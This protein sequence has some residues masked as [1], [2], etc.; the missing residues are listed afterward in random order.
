MHR[1]YP[2]LF[3]PLDLGFTTL[4]NRMIMGSMH[5]GLEEAKGGMKRLARFYAERARGE[6][7]LIIT[8][9]IAPN[10]N[11]WTK[12][13]AARMSHRRHAKKHRI[14]TDSVHKAGGKICMQILHTG[15]YG[16]HPLCV[17]PSKLKSPISPFVPWRLTRRGIH[18]TI[19]DFVRA[20]ELAKLA[21]YDGVE[22]MGSEGYLINEFICQRTNQR[23]DEWGGSYEN[24]IRFPL[25]IV[26]QTRKRVGED[27]III[28][29][30]SMLDLVEGGSSWDEVIRLARAMEQA[31]ATIINTGIGWHES[32][33]PT[34]ATMVPRGA[35]RWVTQKLKPEI[36]IPLIASNRIN[37][38][39][40]ADQTISDGYA[41]L[42][43][44][45]RPFLADASFV[46]KA[47]K[48]EPQ[49]I[50]T[51]IACNQACLDHIFNQK[52]ASCL[53]NPRACHEDQINIST[54]SIRS[55]IGVVGAGP[56]GL[57]FAKTAAQR[58]H[59]VHLYEQSSQ[60]GGQ[61]I[62]AGKIPGKEEYLETIR[63]FR[64]EL[65]KYKVHLHLSHRV[66]GDEM[67]KAGYDKVVIATGIL[68]RKLKLSGIDHPKVCN[69]IDVINNRVALGSKVAIIGAG[70]IGFDVAELITHHQASG[71]RDD[72]S[73]FMKTWG[74]D[75]G[76]S[77]PGGLQQAEK[78]EV[79]REVTM[80]Q[81]SEGK[82][83]KKL[84]KSTGWIHRSTLKNRGVK[85]ISGVQYEKIDDRGLHFIHQ[86][87]S[88]LLEVDNI[89]IC[90]GQ[91]S[92]NEL[93]RQLEDNGI[94]VHIIG[95]AKNADKLDAKR[96]IEEGLRLGIE[97]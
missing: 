6:V 40:L 17:A 29:R 71:E 13:F 78:I 18:R 32:R 23:K 96:A 35:F 63:Y 42:I 62:L 8:G 56:G 46:S 21:G 27:F 77:S 20:A 47:Q 82:L 72:L 12:P 74:I 66:T 37:S 52:I 50:N 86:N 93:Y 70:G 3:Q 64:N 79:S 54:A 80:L 7:G 94:P 61:F 16:Y 49:M 11:G 28:Y 41:D 92:N 76:I 91:V 4:K 34:I 43:S 10:I 30:L 14:I 26:R 39:E 45:A 1:P 65:E 15:R 73:S 67:I 60:L 57:S 83:G 53:V 51:C 69:Y 36:N 84:G 89:I 90:A 5:T 75:R 58:G 59:E 25:E 87:K 19:R 31:G 33:V 38:P 95:G 48:N 68:P 9:G 55:K 97:L 2:G 81:R 85:M 88:T 22:I 44:M 24:R